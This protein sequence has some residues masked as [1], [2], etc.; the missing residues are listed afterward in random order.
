ML[1]AILVLAACLRLV[2]LGS[3][4][5]S[6][7][8]EEAALGYD[9]YSIWKTGSD[10]HGNFWP[11]VAFESFGDYKPSG[12]F[13]TAAPFVGILGLNNWS[14]RLPSALAGI[15][16]VYLVYL[17]GTQLFKNRTIGL[18][19]ALSLAIMP[20]HIQFSRAAFEVNLAVMWLCLGALLLLKSAKKPALTV[21]A[22]F[23]FVLA[24]YTYHG[25]RV[26]GP[27]LALTI[28]ALFSRKLFASRWLWL[29]G[30]LA[31]LLMLPLLL[32]LNNPTV[33]QRFKETSLFSTSDAVVVTNQLRAEDGNSLV[34]RL[35][36]HRYLYWGKE[37]FD[38]MLSH[39]SP[40]FLFLQGDGNQRHQTGYTG[41]LY[42]WQIIPIGLALLMMRKKQHILW[43]AIGLWL[44]WAA[45]P[46]AL[47][48]LTPHTLRFLPAAPA[49]ALITGYGL[50]CLFSYKKR[51]VNAGVIVLIVIQAGAYVFDY[52]TS[53]QQR[54]ATEWQTGYEEL[55]DYV[56]DVEHQYNTIQVTRAYGRPSIYFLYYL[57]IDP[58]VIQN[59][60][61]QLPKDQGELLAFGKFLFGPVNQSISGLAISE[62]ALSAGELVHTIMTSN[63]KP[64]FYIYEI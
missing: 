30:I 62:Q 3:Y 48:N 49:F 5:G 60:N 4:P 28:I 8:W 32:N 41:L 26:T 14:I 10:Y 15:I 64:I 40:N 59:Q 42:V 17:I 53:Y 39:F 50:F 25:L 54:S 19:S 31:A 9:A 44:L 56:A 63:D 45:L 23:A 11:V 52:A 37:I 43:A 61:A 13:Y 22:T 24:S 29:S 12:Y 33:N 35:I 34:S 21:L 1:F 47:T 51:V 57:N 18:W 36:H 38:R 46:A 6:L 58:V 2:G 7:Y 27:L 20:W 16:T 55:V